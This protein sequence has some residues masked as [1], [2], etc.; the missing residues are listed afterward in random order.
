MTKVRWFAG[1]SMYIL[2]VGLFPTYAYA[3]GVCDTQ[4]LAPAIEGGKLNGDA[5]YGCTENHSSY[6]LK[7][8]LQKETSPG[9][10]QDIKCSTTTAGSGPGLSHGVNKACPIDG[11]QWRT[12]AR[13]QVGDGSVHIDTKISS[14]VFRNC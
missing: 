10:F 11:A 9:I 4:V 7:V 14:S 5:S 1:L 2:L 3:H 13:G 6:T 12:W 8:C